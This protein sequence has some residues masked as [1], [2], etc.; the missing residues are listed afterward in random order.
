MPQ[1]REYNW[2]H[3]VFFALSP[4]VALIGVGYSVYRYGLHPGDLASFAFTLGATSLAINAGYHHYYSHRSYECH[5]IVQIFYLLFGAA[6]IQKSALSWASRHRAHHRFVDQEGDPYNIQKGFFWAHLGW[7][8]YQNPVPPEQRYANVPDLTADPLAVWQDRYYRSLSLGTCVLLPLVIG[9]L[10]G[11]PWGS[12]LW[13]GLLR[14]VL[15]QHITFLINSAGHSVGSQ[16]Y[17]TRDS[18][19]DNWWLAVLMFGG[20]YHNFHH[21]FPSDYRSSFAWHQWDPAKWWIWSLNC[22]GLT[23]HLKRTPLQA[24]VRA[25]LRTERI[26]AERGSN[27]QSAERNSQCLPNR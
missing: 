27:A 7:A 26:N 1:H 25:R 18:S 11:R 4:P 22:V 15:F 3:I 14:M 6:A 10:Y 23:R 8:L 5:R 19:R 24:I 13:G 2:I 17:S 21:T 20:G 9:C 12:L 16:P